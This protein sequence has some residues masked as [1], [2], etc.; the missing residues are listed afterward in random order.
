MG[1]VVIVLLLWV[2]FVVTREE[3]V[4]VGGRGIAQVASV[5]VCDVGDSLLLVD[6]EFV[7]VGDIVWELDSTIAS[8][9]LVN[10]W[11]RRRDTVASSCV[12]LCVV[13]DVLFSVV[14]GVILIS[15]V[16]FS[17]VVFV[18]VVVVPEEFGRESDHVVSM[19]FLSI[20]VL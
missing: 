15:V 14:V 19:V 18:V 12:L 1:L 13:C 2:R 3:D 8:I 4:V 16:L 10:A 7:V 17:S 6:F 20:I 5:G 11:E 9:F